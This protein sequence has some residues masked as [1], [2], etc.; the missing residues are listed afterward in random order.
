MHDHLVATQVATSTSSLVDRSARPDAPVV[1]PR[2][3]RTL[4]VRIRLAA[5]LHRIAA[6][7]EARP[8]RERPV[9][10]APACR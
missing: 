2:Q 8:R 3:R 9:A 10:A 4:D 6:A 1:A 5:R 7:L